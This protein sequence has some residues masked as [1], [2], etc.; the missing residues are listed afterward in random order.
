MAY[1]RVSMATSE[2]LSQQL[3]LPEEK[4]EIIAYGLEKLI[5]TSLGFVA[6]ILVGWVLQV[7]KET[8]A[9]AI[10]GALL[11]KYSGGSHSPSALSCIVYGAITYPA[12]AWLAHFLFARFGSPGWLTISVA[13]II[14][15]AIVN[16]YAP[17][18]SPGK[19]IVSQEFRRQ[20]HFT[21]LLVAGLAILAAL[22]LRNTSLSLAILAGL[23]L[24]TVSLL[25]KFKYKE[26]KTNE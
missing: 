19:P 18:D 20:L 7:G 2:Y 16:H 10:V 8:I 21:S 13:G 14:I 9:A 25:P 6:I 4:K 23:A 11:R 12:M 22:Y 15:L 5:F 17:V 26:V 3:G 1:S 24:Q